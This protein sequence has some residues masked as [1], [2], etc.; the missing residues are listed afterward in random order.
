MAG[1]REHIRQMEDMNDDMI[2]EEQRVL[3]R[4]ERIT[5][6]S[7]KSSPAI[8]YRHVRASPIARAQHAQHSTSGEAEDT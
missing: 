1:M 5:A 3:D 7:P 6:K 8:A 4:I 2:E